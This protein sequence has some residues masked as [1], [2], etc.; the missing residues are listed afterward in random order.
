MTVN[1]RERNQQLV[2]YL[3][4]ERDKI[5]KSSDF[6]IDPDLRATYQFITERISQ[7]KM[8]Q[9]QER[10]T[11]FEE[12]L[13]A[14]LGIEQSPQGDTFQSGIGVFSWGGVSIAS[15][16]LYHGT[17]VLGKSIICQKAT[18]ESPD[19]LISLASRESVGMP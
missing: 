16:L 3:I 13:S 10:Y 9:F 14:M 12:R 7:L 1:I 11:E 2:D 17:P 4:K 15:P 18:P 8:E 6:R 5:E 19:R